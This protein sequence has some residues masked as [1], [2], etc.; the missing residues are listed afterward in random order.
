[1]RQLRLIAGA[2][3]LLA[4][5][6][7]VA[8]AQGRGHA[9]GRDQAPG[10]QKK[11]EREARFADTDRDYARNWYAHERRGGDLPPGLRRRELPPGLRDRDRL[12][13]GLER[14]LAAGYVIE[15]PYRPQ[16][17]PVP[18]ELRRRFA[19][20]PAGFGYYAFGGRILLVDATFRVAD[21]LQLEI[22]IGR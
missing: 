11:A 3:L 17:F 5:T 2:A 1:M 10:Q 21:V 6:S 14:R 13:P 20:P 4:L 15:N 18:I 9:R 8:V 22:G 12:P 7:G 16:L 19:H